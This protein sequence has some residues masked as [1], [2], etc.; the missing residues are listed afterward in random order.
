MTT[1]ALRALAG[2]AAGALVLTALNE[3]ARQRVPHAPRMDVIGMRALSAVLRGLGLRP[4]RGRALYRGTLAGDLVSNSLYYALVGAGSPRTRLRRGI[5]LGAAAGL[6]A[7]VV[8]PLIGL[9]HQPG[10]RRPD[11]P[12]MTVAWYTAGGVAA[13]LAGGLLDP[14]DE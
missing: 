13:A 8:P 2:G 10:E 3:G 5:L 6:G 9:G 7:A 11:T 12:L 1:A 4:L 14:R